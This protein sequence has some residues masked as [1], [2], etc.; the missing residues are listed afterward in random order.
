MFCQ[1][2]EC[3]TLTPEQAAELDW[4]SLP[5]SCRA[6]RDA[7]GALPAAKFIL[8]YAGRDRVY[9]PREGGLHDGHEL[10]DLLGLDAAKK[11]ASFA[12]GCPVC[13]PSGKALMQQLVFE[14]VMEKR[15]M[16]WSL[17]RIQSTLVIVY[18]P[19]ERRIRQ[20]LAE[21]RKERKV[22]ATA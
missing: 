4:S 18:R 10:V 22:S 11:L 17:S 12:Q 21:A 16:G 9:V 15:S 8:A 7:L 20:I 19:T 5:E 6:L 14:Y 13:V 2:Q 1:A 3:L